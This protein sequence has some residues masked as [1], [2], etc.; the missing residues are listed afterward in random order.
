MQQTL[1]AETPI[2]LS[3]GG[4]LLIHRAGLEAQIPD[5]GVISIGVKDDI[6]VAER[7]PHKG[8]GPCA[9]CGA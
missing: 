6:I 3:E 2:E 7:T 5:W 9:D 8:I 4:R 1:E